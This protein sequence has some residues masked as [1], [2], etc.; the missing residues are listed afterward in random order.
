MLPDRP[1]ILFFIFYAA[2]TLAAGT[3]TGLARPSTDVAMIALLAGTLL[4]AAMLR[5]RSRVGGGFEIGLLAWL[6]LAVELSF[7]APCQERSLPKLRHVVKMTT[8]LTVA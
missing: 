8:V 2:V 5:P 1:R 6:S 4:A 3:V 7:L